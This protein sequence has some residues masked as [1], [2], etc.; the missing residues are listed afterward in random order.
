[1]PVRRHPVAFSKLRDP[2][3]ALPLDVGLVRR[4]KS[5]YE[6][7][8]AQEMRLA[9]VFYAKLFAAAPQLRS[10]FK[11]DPAAQAQKLTATLDFVVRNLERPQENRE[12]LAALGKRHVEY[13]ARPEHYELVIE[14]L[15]QS[16][17]EILGPDGD[18]HRVDEWRTAL[19]LIGRQMVEAAESPEKS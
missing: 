5:T 4:L 16:M 18:A 11:S 2:L 9:E 1:M 17:S 13:G 12:M 8:R 3:E 15:T 6:L 19:R 10:L 14:L 7:A